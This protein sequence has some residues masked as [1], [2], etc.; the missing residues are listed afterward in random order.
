MKDR[1]STHSSLRE[2]IVEHGFVGDA[3]RALWR[4]EI[5]NVEVLRSEFDAH[6]YDLVMTRGHIVRHIQLKTGQSKTPGRVSVALTLAAKPSGCVIWIHVNDDLDMGPYFWFGG[7]PGKQLPRISN[8]EVPRRTT[9]N[10]KGVK[11]YRKNHRL[12][13]KERFKKIDTLEGVLARLF[14]DL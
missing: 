14:G 12:I 5:I 11:P 4:H 3:L 7:N 9:H 1:H 10:K 8:F 2:R 6:G 13:P